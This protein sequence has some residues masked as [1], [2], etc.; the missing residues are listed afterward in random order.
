MSGEELIGAVKIQYP[1]IRI[2]VIT[3]SLLERQEAA[4]AAGADLVI[5]KPLDIHAL[6][7]EAERL[8]Y[9]GIP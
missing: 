6:E 4:K 5:K 8:L 3:A 9:K 7:K 2:I 1:L